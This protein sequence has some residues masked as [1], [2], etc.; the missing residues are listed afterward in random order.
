MNKK[1]FT[2]IEILA[3]VIILGILMIIAIPSVT[4]YIESSRKS[5]Y[6]KTIKDL[7]AS[8]GANLSK[9][10]MKQANRN[11]TYYIPNSCIK[12][13]NGVAR[14]PYSEF[15]KA[16]IV[17]GWEDNNYGI[18]WLGRDKT[19]KGIKEMKKIA[20]ITEDDIMSDIES[21]DIKINKTIGKT[22]NINLL[23]SNDC[24][25]LIEIDV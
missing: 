25:T 21:D 2:L 24:N 5:A 17:V 18:Y 13:E 4:S 7:M 6:V 11:T 14:S 12:T 15:D 23:D 3:V 20:N 22:T 1:G 10:Q 19:G 16:Y 9:G 8:A